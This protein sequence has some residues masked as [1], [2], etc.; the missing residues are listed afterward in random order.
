[1]HGW[2]GVSLALHYIAW[3]SLGGGGGLV[4]WS[5][6]TH[7]DPMNCNPPVSSVHGIFQTRILEWVASSFSRG[8]L[9]P[10]IKPTCPAWQEDSLP[11][12]H[13]E[14][15]F[16]LELTLHSTQMYLQLI[17]LLLMKAVILTFSFERQKLSTS[18]DGQ[19]LTH[20]WESNLIWNRDSSTSAVLVDQSLLTI[21]VL[22]LALACAQSAGS[23][24]PVWGDFSVHHEMNS[25]VDPMVSLLLF[26]LCM[27]EN[28]W[29]S[30][31]VSWIHT[32]GIEML[33]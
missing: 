16:S 1:M 2:F 8:S 33:L 15:W 30:G 4:F 11:L 23:R 17:T 12:S 10:G 18:L 13:L 21:N 27:G 19:T 5:C 7:C 6:L 32:L 9:G 26:Q 25:S 3:L 28:L 24:G 31:K 20:W 22:L 14:S 29:L